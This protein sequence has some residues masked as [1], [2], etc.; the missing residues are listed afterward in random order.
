MYGGYDYWE[1]ADYKTHGYNNLSGCPEY[2][3]GADPTYRKLPSGKYSVEIYLDEHGEGGVHW[4]PGYGFHFME[5]PGVYTDLNGGC[6]LQGKP[7][8]GTSAIQ[9]EVQN[10]YQPVFG[11]GRYKSNIVRKNVLNGFNKALYF[12]AKDTQAG[13]RLAWLVT[14]WYTEIDGNG[15]K[16]GEVV[17]F[18]T[19]ANGVLSVNPNHAGSV[20]PNP[21]S[22]PANSWTCITMQNG[23]NDANGN[24][25]ADIATVT[26]SS[27]DGRPVEA[28]ADF[29]DERIKRNIT[30]GTKTGGTPPPVDGKAGTIPK[31]AAAGTATPTAAVFKAAGVAVPQVATRALKVQRAKFKKVR[32][33]GAIKR[34]IVFAKFVSPTKRIK[35]KVQLMGFKN[36]KLSVLKSFKVT[37]KANTKKMIRVKVIKNKKLVKKV[38]SIRV[39]PIKAVGKLVIA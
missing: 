36:G 29:V 11:E 27:T 28:I 22:H 26:V 39:T 37:K 13:E 24:T 31:G 20:A 19:G 5:I 34:G 15:P 10:P 3:D 33:H 35:A 6:D 25:S 32:A 23:V 7:I 38:R 4:N 18:S 1:F 2:Y 9:A 21:P 14:A 16:A 30:V 8:L 17:C 12:E